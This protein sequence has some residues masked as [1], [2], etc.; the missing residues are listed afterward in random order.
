M[1]TQT[2]VQPSSLLPSGLRLEPFGDFYLFKFTEELQLRLEQLLEQNKNDM[3]AE[4]QKAELEGIGELERIFTLINAQ[5]A[6]N[7]KWCPS[8]LEN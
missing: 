1:L 2:M 3:L 5:I 6:A 7:A 8:K 4:E